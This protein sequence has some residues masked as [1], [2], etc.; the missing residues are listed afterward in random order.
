MACNRIQL[1]EQTIGLVLAVVL[2]RG[3]R[4]TLRCVNVCERPVKVKKQTPLEQ[5]LPVASIRRVE[6]DVENVFKK[7]ELP[8]TLEDL[9]ERSS[10]NLTPAEIFESFKKC[11]HCMMGTLD[12]HI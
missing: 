1:E 3:P 9:F 5:L 10:Q 7:E 11:L 2:L 8:E 6:A 12:G 4:T